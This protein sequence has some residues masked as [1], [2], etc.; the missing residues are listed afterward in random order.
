MADDKI[1]LLIDLKVD[2]GDQEQQIDSFTKKIEDLRTE[3]EKLIQANKDLKTAGQ[4]NNDTFIDNAKQIELNRAAIADNTAQRRA[5]IQAITAED[6]SLQAIKA[7]LADNT[8]ERNNLNTATAEG[9]KRFDELTAAMKADTDSLGKAEEAGGS[10]S[11]SVGNYSGALDKLIPGLG[12]TANGIMATVEAAEAFI[13]TPIGIVLA[14]VAAVLATV[15]AAAKTNHEVANEL[16]TVWTQT[17]SVANVLERRIG[18]VGDAYLKV[19]LHGDIKG[20]IKDMTDAHMGLADE[21]GH[22]AD[23]SARLS[24]SLQGLEE[25]EA[26]FNVTQK[27]TENEVQ[28]LILASKNRTLTEQQRI[29]LAT[30][31]AQKETTMT[32]QLMALKQKEAQDYLDKAALEQNLNNDKTK[33]LQDQYTLLVQTGKY[34]A[35]DNENLKAALAAIQAFQGAV[36]SSISIEE[37]IQNRRDELADKAAQRQQQREEDKREAL[38]FVDQ[39]EKDLAAGKLKRDEDTAYKSDAIARS[40]GT[41]EIQLHTSA[42]QAIAKSNAALNK[43]IAASDAEGLA[44]KLQNQEAEISGVQKT[45]TSA[46]GLFKQG[47]AAYKVTATAE[48]ILNTRAA[49]IAAYKAMVGI[50]VIGPILAPIAAGVAIGYGLEQVEQINQVQFAQGGIFS[51]P[52][53]KGIK[54]GGRSH[55]MGGTQFFGS[56]GSRFTAEE[57]ENLYILRKDASAF[58][59]Q[60]NFVNHEL[61]GG[62]RLSG[63][64]RFFAQGGMFE[65]QNV[66]RQTEQARPISDLINTLNVRQPVLVME[67]FEA[68]QNARVNTRS[69]AELLG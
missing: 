48:A 46:A 41:V 23:E 12:A 29:D 11:R 32:Q 16:S 65:T 4:G 34:S 31:A 40:S 60:L 28:R 33:T 8:K 13:A 50:P 17:G 5:A 63:G 35:A 57:G 21:M 64:G 53:T 66:A 38:L 39:L 3:N 69:Q 58:I 55:A 1:E 52:D 20:A 22:A 18:L 47:T 59:N 9:K 62:A 42:D 44:L 54:V 61:Y 26:I 67:E 6:N 51:P 45:L 56:D 19:F 37:K 43:K 10:W 27:D 68:K 36:S 15:S 14:A 25:D 2:R 30:Q 7:R 24:K 49:A